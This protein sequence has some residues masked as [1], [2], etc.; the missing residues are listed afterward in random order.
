MLSDRRWGGEV[1]DAILE[2]FD[3]FGGPWEE[4]VV[5]L[6]SW[7]ELREKLYKHAADFTFAE[8]PFLVRRALPCLP[9]HCWVCITRGAALMSGRIIRFN[10][11]STTVFRLQLVSPQNSRK[12]LAPV[13]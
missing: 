9:V 7:R 12:Y 6:F 13:S 3:I 2:L 11:L 5:R 4:T 1:F 10:F 8:Y